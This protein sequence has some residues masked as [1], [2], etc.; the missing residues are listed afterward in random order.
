[1]FIGQIYNNTNN[2]YNMSIWP[3]P[4]FIIDIDEY[5]ELERI[6]EEERIRQYNEDFIQNQIDNFNSQFT[7]YD[8]D[9]DD[10]DY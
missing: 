10:D 9:D 5:E 6:E 4:E 1:M 2:N 8:D 3:K 7:N